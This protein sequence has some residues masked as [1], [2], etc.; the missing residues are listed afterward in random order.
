MHD[1]PPL[2]GVCPLLVTR[3]WIS[4]RTLPDGFWE[5]HF[6]DAI[7]DGPQKAASHQ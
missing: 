4:K 3:N 6:R 7:S 5:I 1:W 2:L